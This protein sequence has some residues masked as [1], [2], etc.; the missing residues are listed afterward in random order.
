MQTELTTTDDAEIETG[1]VLAGETGT[2]GGGAF[3]LSWGGVVPDTSPPRVG[4]WT[5][6]RPPLP[7]IRVLDHPSFLTKI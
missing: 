2:P 6:L 1:A 5:C 7:E 3:W 4:S